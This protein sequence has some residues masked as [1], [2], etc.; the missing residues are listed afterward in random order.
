MPSQPDFIKTLRSFLFII[1]L[2]ASLCAAPSR[3]VAQDDD[4]DDERG[5][6]AEF[7]DR[8]EDEEDL[9]RELWEY[10]KGTP[11]AGALSYVAAAQARAQAARVAEAVLPTG[12]KLA[13]AGR[14]VE[15]GRLPYEAVPFAG[16]LVVLNTGYYTREPQEV[17]VVEPASGRVE[18]TLRI[19]SLFPSATVGPG[20][21]LYLSG[22]FDLKVIRVDRQ[23]N[24][25]REYAVAGYAAGLAALDERRLAVLYLA[26]KDDKGN[27]ISGRLAVLDTETGKVE[28]ETEAG[29]FP[30]SVRQI[31]GKLYVTVLGE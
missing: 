3:V 23:F 8:A 13:P 10:V 5:K 25:A 15:L 29:Y 22:G 19:N 14:Q 1:A 12:W 24:V 7:F 17:S 18:K 2:V 20:G 9:N 21:D 6:R 28:R 4:D 11:Y 30:Y 27:Y 26:A 16:R 31:G